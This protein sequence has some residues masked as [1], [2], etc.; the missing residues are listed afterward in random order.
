MNA[1]TCPCDVAPRETGPVGQFGRLNAGQA[2][3]RHGGTHPRLPGER[4]ARISFHVVSRQLLPPRPLSISDDDFNV[5]VELRADRHVSDV[6]KRRARAMIANK[7][8]R[9]GRPPSSE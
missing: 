5:V 6:V 7:E 1:S 8:Q 2:E 9:K 4:R 3:P